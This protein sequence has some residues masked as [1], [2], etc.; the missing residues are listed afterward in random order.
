ME[1][2]PRDIQRDVARIQKTPMPKRRRQWTL[3]FV[4]ATGEVVTFRRYKVWLFFYMT[5]LAGAAAAAG[6]FWFLSRDS[7]AE[8]R[9]LRRELATLEKQLTA[10]KTEK[11]LMMARMVVTAAIHR[12][13][14]TEPSAPTASPALRAPA[15]RSEPVPPPAPAAPAAAAD[16]PP[17]EKLQ[18][19]MD[20]PDTEAAT[21]EAVKA[22][23]VDVENLK[24]TI[25]RSDRTIHAR[26][27]L[28]KVNVDGE[29]TTGR[30]FVILRGESAA[31]HQWLVM[32]S[33]S[34]ENGRPGRV[35]SGRFFSIA[36]FNI[37]QF[38]TA[39]NMQSD[40][41]SR[42]SVLVY[43]LKGELLLEKHFDIQLKLDP[44]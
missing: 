35:R 31:G 1:D 26:F 24:V 34:L 28:K 27:T 42:A 43:S 40:T 5:L 22:P 30:T 6:T 20:P 29:S 3:M 9:R 11:E 16:S 18:A 25:D 32:P 12:D 39:L 44:A 7:L 36:R 23:P 15:A 41:I 8:N 21:T 14:G 38:N 13:A 10:V 19:S 4:G 37:V 33:V 2:I 17:Q